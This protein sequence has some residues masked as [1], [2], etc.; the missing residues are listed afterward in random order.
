MREGV[1]RKQVFYSKQAEHSGLIVIRL[2]T[3]MKDPLS[4][5]IHTLWVATRKDEPVAL[6]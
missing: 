2:V 1:E 6:L 5:V 4:N 3:S